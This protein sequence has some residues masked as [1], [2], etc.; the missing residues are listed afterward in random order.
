MRQVIA[1]NG[2]PR[3]TTTHR[4]LESIADLLEAHD[5]KVTILNLRD[6]RIDDCIGCEQCIRKTSRCFQADDAQEILDRIVASD[7]VILASPVYLMHITG[8]LKSLIDKTAS[9]VHRPPLVGKP[10]ISVATTAGAGL[11]DVQK[12]LERIAMQWGLHPTGRIGRSLQDQR[13]VLFDDVSSFLWHL[14]NPPSRYTVT[15]AQ[16]MQYQVQRVLAL[17]VLAVDLVYWQDRGWNKRI[18]FYEGRIS[19]WKR[20]IACSFYHLLTIRIQSRE[21]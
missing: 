8:R 17:K 1:I 9:W 2:S 12:Y 18:F 21:P 3:K 10:M 16:L 6:H 5:V 4:L 14:N 11:M 13:P 15:M 20:V 7:G 19:W